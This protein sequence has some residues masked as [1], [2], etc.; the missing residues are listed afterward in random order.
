MS[1]DPNTDTDTAPS[2]T[3]TINSKALQARELEWAVNSAALE[4][5]H[6]ATNGPII[7]TRFPPEPN[8]YLHI[9]HAKSMNMNFS[10]AFQKLNVAPEHR[11]T[12][13]RYDDTNPDA[14][15][16]EY[17]DSIRRDLD[18]LGWTPERTT[19]SSDNFQILHDFAVKLI[20]KGLA[21][22]CDMTGPE[23]KLQRDLALRRVKAKNV[24]QDPDEV[25]PIPSPDVLPGRNRNTSVQRNLQMFERM[26]LGMY[27]EGQYTLRLKMDFESDNPNMYDLVAYRIK[28]TSHP[29]AGRGWCIYPAYDFTHGICDSLEDIDYSICTLEFEVRREPYFWILWALDLY[30]PK[31]YEMSRLNIEYTVLSKRRLIKLVTNNYVRGW[32]D[33]RMPTVSGLRRRGYTKDILNSFCND[34]GA[35]RAENLVEMEKLFSTARLHLSQTSRRAM[36]V[37]DPIKVV[38]TNFDEEVANIKQKGNGNDKNN[39]SDMTFEVQ[40]SPTDPSLGSHTITLT[41]VIYIDASDFRLE[42]NSTYYGLAPNKAVGLKYYG[43]N[44][45]CNKV[46]KNNN[47]GIA[48]IQCTLQSRDEGTKPQSYITWVPENGIPCEIR[49]YNH[50]F[51]VTEP[52]DRWEEE[53]NP[54][55]EIVYPK[56]MVDPSVR[57]VVD[58]KNVNK[59]TSNVALQFERFGYFV[60]DIDTTYDSKSNNGALVFNRT[61]SLREEKEK[62]QLTNKEEQENAKRRLKQQAD[63]EAK[64]IKMKIA[65]VDLFKLAPEYE[66]K[67]SKF[68]D[69]GIP[70]HLVDGTEVTK[71]A[72]KK[73]AKEQM[74]HKKALA[75]HNKTK[76]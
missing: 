14:E 50:L 25:A 23:V 44:L 37:L 5:R 24:G 48:E 21:Y 43:G 9:G 49:V 60:V 33:P 6:A 19:Y 71:S 17:I 3:S 41:K 55:S 15:S 70:T 29:H 76:K 72:M 65:S 68:N 31:V 30:R 10:L 40:N 18:W 62:K 1:D 8:G 47:N 26:R 74:K 45:I 20:R 51:A 32:D 22:V 39:E 4:E 56:A 13:F 42:D 38:I 61:V 66:G 46:I 64:E 59:W 54:N 63:K 12:I 57:E 2:S 35:S 28:Y 69:E 34:V 16:P 27:D 11:R 58:A 7:R 52:S 67:Y 75:N 36:A 73:L 53:L